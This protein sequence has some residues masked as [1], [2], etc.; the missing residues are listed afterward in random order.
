MFYRIVDSLIFRME[1]DFLSDS[2][3]ITFQNQVA[4][5]RN[6]GQIRKGAIRCVIM[7]TVPY[8]GTYSYD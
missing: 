8:N 4:K 1:E 5:M 7:F 2:G 6:S 3:Q